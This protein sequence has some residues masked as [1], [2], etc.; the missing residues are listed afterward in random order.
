M[1]GHFLEKIHFVKNCICLAIMFA[2]NM[3]T[4]Y[5]LRMRHTVSEPIRTNHEICRRFPIL[6]VNSPFLVVDSPILPPTLDE[7]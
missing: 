1:C 2:V 5:Y 6:V 7:G 3:V 4:L